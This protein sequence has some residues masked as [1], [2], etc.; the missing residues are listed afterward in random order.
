MHSGLFFSVTDGIRMKY[1][2][3]LMCEVNYHARFILSF[4]Y[5]RSPNTA[6][7]KLADEMIIE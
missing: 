5:F 6:N 7:N 1:N 4:L 3:L 2:H